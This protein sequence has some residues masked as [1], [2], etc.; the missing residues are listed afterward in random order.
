[1]RQLRSRSALSTYQL[2]ERLGWS[3]A[4]VSKIERG[5]T[6]A[7]PDDVAAWTA[8]TS[9]SDA[10]SAELVTLAGIV[11]DQMR[12][13]REVHRGGLS[14][15]QRELA[16]I[17]AAMTGYREFAPYVVPG[18]LQTGAYAARVLELA[19]VG[20]RGGIADGVAE[21]MA[22]QAVL[23]DPSRSFR[24]VV[25]ES[26]LHIAFGSADVM[27]AQAAKVLAA[28]NL[29]NVSVA[30]LPL[31]WQAVTLTPS[32]FV[33]YDLPDE[34]MV[35]VELLSRELQLRTG[36]DVSVHADA[37]ALLEGASVTGAAAE[38]MIRGMA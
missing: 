5:Q 27:R 31:D 30:V 33:I 3:Q 1:M 7:D 17:H 6:P 37:F 21:R 29:P 14:V 4:K 18:F 23:L 24:F 2:A 22:R 38:A 20:G 35:L 25:T 8:A 36:W 15:R 32:G 26:A 28:M 16:D 34:P 13:W 11:A 12:Q 10:E 19:D 9:A